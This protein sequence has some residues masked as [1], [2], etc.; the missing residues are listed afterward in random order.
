MTIGRLILH[1]IAYRK[2]NFAMSVF[3][4]T[5]AIACLVAFVAILSRHDRR[6]EEIIAAK[7]AQTRAAMKALEDDYR[8]I[9]LQLGFNLHILPKGLDLASWHADE[10]VAVFMPEEYADRLAKSGVATINHVLPIL[11]ERV[12]WEEKGRPILVKGTRGELAIF[13]RQEKKPLRDAVPPGTVVVGHELHRSLGIARGD[14]IA[15]TLSRRVREGEA[16][17]IRKLPTA[18]L[19]VHKL[20]AATGV[21]EEDIALWI[22]LGEA[23]KILQ[24]PG[25]ISEILALECNCEADRL[26]RIHSEISSILPDTQIIELGPQA[27]AR[28]E[29]RNR[30]AREARQAIK[31]EEEHRQELKDQTEELAAV[32]VPVVFLGCLLGMGL[33]AF[34]NVRERASEI[35]IF[36]ALGMRNRPIMAIFVGKAVLTG[37]LGAL[38]GYVV[39]TITGVILSEAGFAISSL[40]DPEMLLLV[41]VGTLLLSVLASWFPAR[42]AVRQ[43]PATVLWEN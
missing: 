9:T 28:A 6:T 21:R 22:N 12:T 36:R 39:G 38:L 8:K 4:V 40:F 5:I 27:Q 32:L 15:L 20:Q 24:R 16:E 30:A 17:I 34:Q 13:K 31:R 33:L 14:K 2:L 7:E 26:A 1:E 23:Q 19:T 11:R 3:T 18:Y 29:A 35:G 43:D 41:L 10:D 25:Q 42:E 37:L